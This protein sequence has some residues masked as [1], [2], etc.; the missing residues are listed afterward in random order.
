M[1]WDPELYT[2]KHSYVY[3]YGEEL[4]GWLAPAAG[5]RILDV[6]CGTGHLTARIAAAG[7]EVV[8]LDAS[9]EMIAVA[10][11]AYP[12][13]EFVRADA[14][15]FSLDR[16]FDAIFSNAALHWVK[17]PEDAVICMARALKPG[18]RFVVEFGGKGNVQLIVSTLEEAIWDL[19][20]K[21][22]DAQNYF[23][24]IGEYASLLEKHGIE[25]I[26]ARLFDRP[27]RLEGEEDGLASWIRMFRQPALDLVPEERQAAVIE[28]VKE[29]LRGLLY[30]DG[31]WYADYRRLRIVGRK[32]EE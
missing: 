6:G 8:G 26:D 27:T 14:T 13:L 24:S 2:D 9:P 7:A 32:V 20:G 28:S 11:A 16:P 25:V 31:H 5:E 21:V 1:N 12:Q 4:L 18:G 29:R 19:A 22:A 15:D 10:Q 30:V 3:R 17:P 23:P